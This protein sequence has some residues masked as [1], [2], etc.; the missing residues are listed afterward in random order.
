VIAVADTSAL[1]AVVQNERGAAEV[2][3]YESLLVSPVILAETLSKA[4]AKGYAPDAVGQDLEEIGVVALPML[5]DDV[6]AVVALHRLARVSVSLADRFCLALA[7]ER[8]QPVLT[9]DRAWTSLG[10]PLDIRLIR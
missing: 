5:P 6:R 8:R 2:L 7:I 9:A 10:L 1:L 4:A 3:R